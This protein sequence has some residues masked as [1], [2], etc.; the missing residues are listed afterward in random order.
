M[1]A[2]LTCTLA[3]YAA[4]PWGDGPDAI[5]LV[6][7]DYPLFGEMSPEQ[8]RK[9]RAPLRIRLGPRGSVHVLA[10]APLRMP[11]GAPIFIHHFDAE[12]KFLGRTPILW[13]GGQDTD[14]LS[15]LDYIVDADGNCYLLE[16]IQSG[17][18]GQSK[19]RLQKIGRDGEVRWSRSGA[20]SQEEFDFTELRGNFKRLLMDGRSR[21]YLPATEHAGAIAKIDGDTGNVAHVYTSDKFGSQVFMNEH[22][23]VIYV[24]YFPELNRRGLGFFDLDKH[25]VTS[26]VGGIES[27]GWLIY[28]IGVDS[29]PN[30]YAW[31]DSAVGRISLDERIDVIA[32]LDNIVV[33]SRDGVI[34]TSRLLSGNEQSRVVQAAR[35]SPAGEASYQELRVPQKLGVRPGVTW[36]LIHVD[37]QEKYY[38]FGGEEPG[39]AGTLLVYSKHGDLERTA[40]PPQNLLPLESNLE[41]HS[42]W[43]VDPNGRIYLPVTD[44]EGFKVLRL[45]TFED[46][47]SP[48]PLC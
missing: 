40:A 18:S 6:L 38:V 13:Q 29:S 31:N 24:L 32:T 3:I 9:V 30:V 15:I 8:M 37:E 39:H 44:A 19:N 10:D 17:Q 5:P 11:K 4:A 23:T 21:L 26:I 2:I 1:P 41:D 16:L 7:E 45:D 25:Q 48:S 14:A 46:E 35:Y 34:F 47:C 27:Y 20:I 36:K 28:P 22:A 12:G 43:E 33:R 42:F